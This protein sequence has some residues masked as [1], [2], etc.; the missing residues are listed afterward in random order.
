MSLLPYL[1]FKPSLGERVFI[2]EGAKV[3]GRAELQ[4][5]VNVWF[6]TVIRA[7]VN[8]IIVGKNTNVQDLCMFHV[9]EQNDLV[10]GENTSFGH[11][12]TLHGCKIG[13]GCLIGM[14]SIILDG[15]EVGD[16]SLVAAGS[17]ITPGKKFPP[18]SFIV[19][20]P[21]VAQRELTAEEKERVKNHY[22]SYIDYKEQYL[23]MDSG[24]QKKNL[25]GELKNFFTI[26]DRHNLFL[27]SSSIAYYATLSFAPLILILLGLAALIGEDVQIQVL[28]QLSLLAPELKETIELVLIN[29]QEQVHFSSISGII[30]AAS[31]VFLASYLFM[32]LRYSF[33]LI[34]GYLEK[35][36]SK[37]FFQLILERGFFMLI[38]IFMCLLFGASLL[39]GPIFE[40]IF[41]IYEELEFL[42][43][44]SKIVSVFGILFLLFTGL[45]FFTPSSKKKIKHCAQMALLTSIFFMIG[46]FLIGLYM[47]TVAVTSL[48]GAAG[49]LLVFLLWTFY[50]SF[51][52]FLSA[53][54]YEF[55]KRRKQRLAV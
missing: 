39:V 28:N 48:Y 46:N 4:D 8:K 3:I 37:S 45:Y 32:Q 11:S 31:M 23:T 22:K 10:I 38:V 47:K 29:L 34:D 25:V 24:E 33:D 30:G 20:R 16:H 40:Y 42:K 36:V 21:A 19:G 1:E 55:V 53:E 54:I 9:T 13:S 15:A 5:H 50:S 26:V 2:A 7:D 43:G 14:G 18:G 44:V 35:N 52:I 41:S 17:L 6:N 12:V 27:L 49:T 51:T